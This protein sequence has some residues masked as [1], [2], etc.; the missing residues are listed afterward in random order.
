MIKIALFVEGLTEETFFSRLLQEM[1]GTRKLQIDIRKQFKGSLQAHIRSS[2]PP[3]PLD[4]YVLI[5]NCQNDE[6]VKT[7]IIDNYQSLGAQGYQLIIGVRDVYPMTHADLPKLRANLGVGLPDGEIPVE[8]HLAV[9]ETEAWFL[10][11]HTHFNR[12][13][14]GL[15]DDVIKTAGFD[16]STTCAED[17][18]NPANTLNVIYQSVGKAYRKTRRQ[19]QRTVDAIDYRRLGT[20]VRMRSTSFAAA[21]GALEAALKLP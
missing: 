17:L 4:W 13:D 1:A 3:H 5:A 15:T 21:I 6:Q 2:A 8:V 19:V 20:D 16:F 9:M 12:I 11:E 7:Q 14:T 18:P 10:E